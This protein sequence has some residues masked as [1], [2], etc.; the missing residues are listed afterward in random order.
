VNS[1]DRQRLT[2][3]VIVGVVGVGISV[4]VIVYPYMLQGAITRYGITG[5]AGALLLLAAI[6]FALPGRRLLDALRG[7]AAPSLGIPV[8]LA[9][10]AA[11][12]Q[13]VYLQLVPC[14][15]YLTLAYLCFASLRADD[16]IVERAAR[17]LIP[18]APAFIRPYCRKV[19][20]LWVAFFL[21]SAIVIAALAVG[22]EVEGWKR[23]SGQILYV[24]ML[25]IS[26]IEFIVRKT[27]FRY[28]FYR[29][30]IDRLWERW[31]P[32]ENTAAGRR[33]MQYIA[34]IRRMS[35][36]GGD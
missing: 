34:D 9:A 28:Y 12:A 5:V 8:V 21:I 36:S 14:F 29:G 10:A 4:G 20:W 1:V 16:S 18:E 27:W 35:R 15:V 19:T 13:P 31:F 25:T 11:T 17:F 22:G 6:S 32:P 26:A 2:N 7:G 24:S 30:P 3:W 23:F 33:S